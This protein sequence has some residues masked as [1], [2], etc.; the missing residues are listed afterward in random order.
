MRII[1]RVVRSLHY[2][3]AT[4]GGSSVI[5]VIYIKYFAQQYN[6]I[7]LIFVASVNPQISN[8]QVVSSLS[9]FIKHIVFEI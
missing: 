3:L 2:T 1:P 5:R 7:L 6:K 9:H 4:G 8:R